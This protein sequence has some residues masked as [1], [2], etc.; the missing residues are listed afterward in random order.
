MHSTREIDQNRLN[1]L[2]AA[3]L[4]AVDPE[5]R[6]CF[7]IDLERIPGKIVRVSNFSDGSLFEIVCPKC[8]SQFTYLS[9]GW[10]DNYLI[11]VIKN[12]HPNDPQEIQDELLD[13]AHKLLFP[14]YLEG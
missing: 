11:N 6:W 14:E 9:E 3:H 7:A 5:C 8:G 12:L 10:E 2:I 1:E 4:E 13:Q